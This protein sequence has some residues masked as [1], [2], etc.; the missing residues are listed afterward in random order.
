MKV[1]VFGAGVIG[2]IYA[3]RLLAAGYDVSMVCHAATADEIRTSGIVLRRNGVLAESV[4][5]RVFLR[6][7]E[8]GSFDIALIAIR[9][10][11]VESARRALREIKAA[12]VVSL[13]DLP[14]GLRKLANVFGA[15]RY[16]PGFPGV[17]GTI[18]S[19]GVVDYLEVDQ[20]PTTIGR[21]SEVSLVAVLFN[22]AGFRTV[23]S[24]DMSAW[25]QTHAIFIS[26][27]ESAIVACGGNVSVLT[28]DHLAM[29]RLVFAIREGLRALR[30]IDVPVLPI[31]I[32]IIFLGM[33][34]WFAAR[35]WRRALA[36]P[37]GAL[38]MAPHSWVSRRTELPALQ[39]DVRII[40][41][42]Q[43]IPLLEAVFAGRPIVASRS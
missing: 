27:I 42:G 2:R 13:I 28:S 23:T 21:T 43:E 4:H 1:L 25:L 12:T 40:L 29:R 19:D 5:P 38:G 30:A 3:A 15:E 31:P 9:R 6:A 16:V 41:K 26:A 18:C 14:L 7:S 39:D 33:P 34:V 24:R 35:Y 22:S 36:G 11:Q 10:D 37:L 20:Q 17:A 8:A 32:R